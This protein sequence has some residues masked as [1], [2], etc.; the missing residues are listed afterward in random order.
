MAGHQ[1]FQVSRNKAHKGIN[2]FKKG[3]NRRKQSK[4]EK[5]MDGIGIW[6]SFYRANPQRF[7]SDYLG[8]NLKLF[9]EILIYMMIHN[10]YFMYL[11]S[12]GQGKTYLTGI[13]CVVRAILFPGTKIVVASGTKSQAREIVDKIDDMRKDSANLAREISDLKSASNDSSVSFHNGS[14][15]KVVASNDNAR[16]KRANLLIVDEFRMVELNVINKVLRKF[17][18]APRQPGYLKNPKYADDKQY[19][20][21]N[22]EMYLSSAWYSHHWSYRKFIAFFKKLVAGDKYFVCGLPYQ[23]AIKEGLY[24]ENQ[25]KDEMSED[26]FDAIGWE[27]EMGCLWFGESEKAYFK[28]EELNNSRTLSEPIYNK[29]QMEI[30]KNTSI[31]KTRKKADEIRLVSCDIAASEGSTND[32]SVFSVLKLVRSGNSYKRQLVYMESIN[33]GN[34]V[35]QSFRI[36]EL[37]EEFQCDYIVLDTQNVGM[38]IYDNLI[39]EQFNRETL[40][41]YEAL[42]CINDESM[43]DRCK[44]EDARGV[45]Y[46][47]KASAKLNSDIAIN[48]RDTLRRNK[49]EL[50]IHENDAKEFFKGVTGFDKLSTE[51]Q[52]R[53]ISPYAQSSSLINEMISLE[54]E[55][56][57]DGKVRLR[58]PSGKR[59][60][61]WSSVSYGNWIASELER[62]LNVKSAFDSESDDEEYIYY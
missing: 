39:L 26:D 14:W 5:L 19:K 44:V 56:S 61:R 7:V 59:K 51:D 48:F 35:T 25:A 23:L 15:I 27:M 20:E 11:A 33:G 57:D 42:T 17:L 36:R 46:S 3:N 50:L 29:D 6:T 53:L 54:A 58:E 16:S 52:A 47:I 12:R 43:A 18:S 24:D 37:F 41:K 28:F 2:I 38:G 1:N 34:T 22:M 9:Q 10:H 49:L 4:S 55:Y 30:L 32:N 31:K 62:G 21:R 45:I 13:Y 40:K 8:I 60:D